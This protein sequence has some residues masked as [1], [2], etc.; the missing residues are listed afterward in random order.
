MPRAD[1]PAKI[2]DHA[3]DVPEGDVPEDA[4]TQL[5]TWIAERMR[6]DSRARDDAKP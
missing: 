1:V 6:A 2:V 3:V 5:G 4:P